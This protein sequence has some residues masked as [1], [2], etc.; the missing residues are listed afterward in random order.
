MGRRLYAGNEV[1]AA[2][3]LGRLGEITLQGMTVGSRVMPVESAE[4]DTVSKRLFAVAF[5]GVPGSNGAYV[6]Y[7]LD[8]ETG[9][10]MPA[11]P[12]GAGVTAM[13]LD[14]E[15]RRL[16]CTAGRYRDLHAVRG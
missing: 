9:E 1:L 2:D 14:R 3:D 5:N 13:I 16:F 12:G 10:Q 15:E 4:V 11:P 6:M 8:T 7:V